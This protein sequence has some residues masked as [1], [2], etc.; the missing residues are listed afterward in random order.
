MTP[1]ASAPSPAAWWRSPR[2]YFSSFLTLVLWI[3]LVQY[4]LPPETWLDP[5]WQE[6]LI[7]AHAQGWQFGREVIFTW[8]PWGFLCSQFHLGATGATARLLWEV[9]GHLVL[10]AAFVALTHRLPVWR[11]LVFVA[12]LALFNW[13]FLDT[14]YLVSLTLVVVAALLRRETP[15]WQLAGWIIACAFLAEFKFTYFVLSAAGV[16]TAAALRIA[17]REL[18]PAAFLIAGYAAALLGFWLLAGQNPDNLV[19]YLRRSLEIAA[20]YANAM[21]V[22]ETPQVFWCGVGL[23]AWCGLFLWQLHR[24]HEDR[25]FAI[26]AT[27]FLAAAWFVVWKHGFTRADG[28]VHGF[29]LYTLL[30]ALALPPLFF[31]SK[32]WHWFELA[33]VLCLLGMGLADSSLLRN[34][35]EIAWSRL[36]SNSRSLLRLSRWPAEWEQARQSARAAA[37]LPD[38]QRTVGRSTIDVYNYD[39]G[40]ALLNGLCYTPRPVFQ[41]YSAYTPRLMAKNLGFYQS[42]GAPDYLLCNFQSI[43]GRYPSTDDATLLV[44]LPRSY[45]PVLEEGDYLLLQKRRPLPTQR[46]ARKPLLAQS[47]ALGE[48]LTLPPVRDQAVW[49]QA[50]CRLTTLGRLRALLYKP[51]LLNMTVTDD[52]GVQTNWRMLPRVAEEGFLLAPLLATPSDFAAFLRG[53]S[54]TWLRS[55]HFRAPPGQEKFWSRA[56]VRLYALPELPLQTDAPF[57]SLLEAGIVDRAPDTVVSLAPLEIF[58]IGPSK[59]MLLH[60]PSEMTLAVPEDATAFAGTFGLRDGSYDHGGQTDGIELLLEAIWADGHTQTLLRRY[61]DPVKQAADRPPQSFQVALPSAPPTKL[62]LRFGAG[63]KEDN[64]WDWSYVTGLRF[65][66]VNRQ[67]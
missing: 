22:D 45:A 38:V 9:C 16:F 11:Q 59:A 54:R 27:V 43:D 26:A 53:R 7:Q 61:L 37:A 31:P 8:G 6:V 14:A 51:P 39:Q 4:P 18:R 58:T 24:S 30:L 19:P 48:E 15:S 17:R 1:P 21:G 42:E 67:P 44:E 47:L 66:P 63:P 20:G 35:P 55:L 50:T 34:C 64:R 32:K 57:A 46:L 28:H 25:P 65:P 2:L 29:F 62:R 40:A 49:L 41:S 36:G 5:S 56:D 10:A 60:A 23:L 12:A 52:R 3:S 13:V 33:P